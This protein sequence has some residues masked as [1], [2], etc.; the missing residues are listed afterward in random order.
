MSGSILA[1]V[2][3]EVE[4]I[5]NDISR[6]ADAIESNNPSSANNIVSVLEAYNEIG[7]KLDPKLLCQDASMI[8]PLNRRGC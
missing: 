2:L 8:Y 1:V 7:S 5:H 3:R 4:K 6:W